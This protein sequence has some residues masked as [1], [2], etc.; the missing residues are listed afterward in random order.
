LAAPRRFRLWAENR[1]LLEKVAH[2]FDLL[3]GMD[4]QAF[5]IDEA[6]VERA[7]RAPSIICRAN[8]ACSL[9]IRI[10]VLIPFSTPSH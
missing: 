3:F 2:S 6:V 5:P 1:L 4:Q 7:S 9:S 8:R 10:A